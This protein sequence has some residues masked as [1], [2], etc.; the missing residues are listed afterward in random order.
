MRYGKEIN[1]M[2]QMIVIHYTKDKNFRLKPIYIKNAEL[3]DEGGYWCKPK[4]GIW[5]SPVESGYGWKEWCDGAEFENLE[6]MV[7]VEMKIDIEKFIVIDKHSDMNKL[8]WYVRIPG[9]RIEFIDFE[10]LVNEGI[11]G[12]H[13][14][15][16]GEK[17]TRF[18]YIFSDKHRN[19]YG[20]DC[21]SIL[22]LNERCIKEWHV[23]L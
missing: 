5:A 19:L 20:W 11:E 6:K 23:I 15:E 17:K 3:N 10:K 14:T 2:K 18:P 16:Q 12:I 9:T 1:E 7:K 22:I 21:E 8:P 13:L 4:G